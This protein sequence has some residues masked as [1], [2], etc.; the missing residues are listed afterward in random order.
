MRRLV[1]LL[2]LPVVVL[3][4]CSGSK[5]DADRDHRDGAG[6]AVA[7]AVLIDVRTP[8]EFAGGH[9]EGARN[10]DLQGP[11]FEGKVGDLDRGER[12]IVYC[13]SGNRSGQAIE[14]MKAMGF[15]DLENGGGVLDAAERYGV[16]II[17]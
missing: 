6:A 1:L 15:T 16:E 13:R 8:E 4:A 17:T 12:Y 5:A 2:L 3:S 11:D 9:L 14:I 7:D 10:I